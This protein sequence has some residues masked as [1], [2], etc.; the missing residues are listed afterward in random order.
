MW[1]EMAMTSSGIDPATFR[2]VA[3]CLHQLRHRET[4]RQYV[5]KGNKQL[6]NT[7]REN[8]LNFMH[9]VKE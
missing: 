6:P 9:V 4:P 8:E 2:L 1:R 5:Q 7:G 3:Q